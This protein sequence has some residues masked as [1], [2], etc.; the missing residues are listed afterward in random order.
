MFDR[1][2]Q[3]W[4]EPA[5][6][7]SGAWRNHPPRKPPPTAPPRPLEDDQFRGP[8]GR[9]YGQVPEDVDR[10]DVCAGHKV[11]LGPDGVCAACRL[12]GG[13][14]AKVRPPQRQVVLLAFERHDANEWIQGRDPV[15][16]SYT[17]NS[18]IDATMADGSRVRVVTAS[19]AV[20]RGVVADHVCVTSDYYEL[21]T[22]ER[23]MAIE[24]GLR[25][26]VAG[27]PGAVWDVPPIPLTE[28]PASPTG[29]RRRTRARVD[30]AAHEQAAQAREHG[31]AEA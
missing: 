3:W 15:R 7:S 29:T 27:R 22:P 19:Q 23:R 10:P 20:P 28:Q 4:S 17:S 1:L 31:G 6:R 9:V 5:L 30:G 2:K 25:P 13:P 11:R 21:T 12:Y 24:Q 26:I 18:G 16:V 14:W 8:D